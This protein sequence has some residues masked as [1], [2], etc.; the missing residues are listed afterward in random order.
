MMGKTE[1][2]I[3]YGLMLA[4]GIIARFLFRYFRS[5]KDSKPSKKRENSNIIKQ[6]QLYFNVG[7]LGLIVFTS[8]GIFAFLTETE[9]YYIL[10]FMMDIPYI[11][12]MI[13]QI[14]WEIQVYENE[15]VFRNMWR[16]SRTYY[17]DDIAVSELTSATRFYKKGK[18]IVGISFLQ[19]NWDCLQNA[20]K[21]YRKEQNK[22][23]KAIRQQHNRISK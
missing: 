1:K 23:E 6:P 16:I 22:I 8:G 7:L 13:I 4:V 2:L 12:F 11:L 10:I 15:F 19:D 20:I 9:P 14:N 21:A 5:K 3:F 18:H 17:F